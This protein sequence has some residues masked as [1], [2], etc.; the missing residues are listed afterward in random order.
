MVP[1]DSF[2]VHVV[3]VVDVGTVSLLGQLLPDE[4]NGVGPAGLAALLP[5]ALDLL[6]AVPGEDLEQAFFCTKPKNSVP[7]F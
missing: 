4:L 1:V 7:Y 3:I 2:S 5:V 6:E